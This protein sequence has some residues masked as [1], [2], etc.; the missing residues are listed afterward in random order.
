MT[1]DEY[2]ATM[3]FLLSSKSEGNTISSNQLPPHYQR[4][5]FKDAVV[6]FSEGS[7]GCFSVQ[8]IRS[9][10]W[11]IGWLNFSIRKPI[12]LNTIIDQPMVAIVCILKGNISYELQGYGNLMLR[13][14]MYGCYYI[15]ADSK[16]TASFAVDEHEAVYCSF[17]NDFLLSFVTQHPNFQQLYDAQQNRSQNGNALSTFK[18]NIEERRIL[19]AIRQ[20]NLTGPAKHIF[21]HARINDLLISYFNSLEVA[22]KKQYR[23]ID[24]QIRL[25]E[26]QVFIQD[27]FHLPLKVQTLSKQAGMNL[28]SFEKGFKELF[29]IR[30][31]EYIEQ[32]RVSRAAQLL[33]ATNIPVTSIAYQV[34][35]AGT[36]YFSFVFRKIHN[37]S[38]R[39]FRQK[40]LEK[41]KIA[42][43]QDL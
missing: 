16:N 17:S 10:S 7:F 12:R 1:T 37:C 4:H 15:P 8:E 42:S 2:P 40:W 29:G 24:Q 20:C 3:K 6:E 5:A 13:K 25:R 19:D 41:N 38:P 14:N 27:N 32:Q 18:V 22:D 39:E 31:K 43:D 28:R 34:G 26:I 11:V 30:P 23:S 35:F 36:N 33:E 21:F 9:K